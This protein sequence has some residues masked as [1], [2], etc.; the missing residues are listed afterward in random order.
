VV[1]NLTIG[2]NAALCSDS[3]DTIVASCT[4]GGTV[5]TFGNMGSCP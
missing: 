4:I 5:S 1:G 3:V 2:D